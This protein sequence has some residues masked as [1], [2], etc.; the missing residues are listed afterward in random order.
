MLAGMAFFSCWCRSTIAP[1]FD[2]DIDKG[3]RVARDENGKRIEVKGD[4]KYEE[5]VRELSRNRLKKGD[6]YGKNIQMP[7]ALK[8]SGGINEEIVEVIKQTLE[9]AEK[10]LGIKID[11][12]VYEDALNDAGKINE[13]V[14]FQCRPDVNGIMLNHTFVINKSFAWPETLAKMN[15]MVHNENKREFFASRDLKDLIRHEAAHF[16]TFKDCI[17]IWQYEALSDRLKDEFI[18]GVTMYSDISRDG[19]EVIA[20]AYILIRRGASVA[21]NVRILVETYLYKK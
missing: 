12:V 20:E 7:E 6:I 14:I 15:E 21:E 1:Y 8:G 13:K 10:E 9:E 16:A 17:N 19:A 2:D 11:N 18:K 3:I 5:W 4:M